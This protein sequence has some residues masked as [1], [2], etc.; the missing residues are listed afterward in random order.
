MCQDLIVAI[1]QTFLSQDVFMEQKKGQMTLKSYGKLKNVD[2]SKQTKENCDFRTA[3]NRNL[4]SISDQLIKKKISSALKKALASCAE[5]LVKKLPINEQTVADARALHPA[6]RLENREAAI[7]RLAYSVVKAAGIK[8]V[9]R[10]FGTQ[11][12]SID[13]IVDAVKDEYKRWKLE[14]IP[15]SYFIE[16][17]ESKLNLT[18]P[19]YWREEYNLLDI[20][21]PNAQKENKCVPVDAYW[22]KVGLMKDEN[23]MKKYKH[24]SALALTI[25]T[26]SHGNADPERG[27]SINKRLLKIHSVQIEQH[28]L[29]S[30]RLI[31]G[32]IMLKGGLIQLIDL[33]D[34]SLVRSVQSSHA[35]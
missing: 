30:I 18:R 27:F 14:T 22:I 1:C 34:L 9:Q 26:L 10:E 24:L 15:E 35:K 12:S 21:S 23:G 11:E 33:I 4:Q 20:E 28:I 19:S 6:K 29:V 16:A 8:N 2:F 31:K 17:G 25:L 32:W 7:G 3:A 5:Y 13:R